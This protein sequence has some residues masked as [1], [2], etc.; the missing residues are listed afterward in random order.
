MQPYSVQVA[1]IIGLFCLV[2]FV[3][4]TLLIDHTMDTI[5]TSSSP[6]AVSKAIT[7]PMTADYRNA[8]VFRTHALTR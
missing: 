1:L 3:Q 4:V 5:V 8:A 7:V 6:L 2:Y